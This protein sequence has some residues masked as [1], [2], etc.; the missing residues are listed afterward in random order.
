LPFPRAK[1]NL[2]DYGTRVPLAIRWGARV[3]PRRVV[4][5]FVSFPDFAPTFLEAAGLR[6]PCEMTGRSLLRV[7][8]S[9]RSGQ[10]DPARDCAVFGI[11]RGVRTKDY[12][13][14]R[15]LT[16]DASPAGDH[17]GP[18][19]PPDDPTGGYGDSDGGPSKT[20]LW[21]NREKYAELFRLAFGKRPAEELYD[22]NADP[23]Q[24]RNLAA[25]PQH[26]RARRELAARLDRHLR[27]TGDPRATGQGSQLDAVMR[28][29]PALGMNQA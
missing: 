4:E 7:L 2:Y 5:D 26:A 14:I 20:C 16:P 17:P 27:R 1:A 28:R 21:Q 25:D 10:V 6:A 18:V 3:P 8:L 24:L 19:W 29:Y 11:A 15:N 9:G 23:F 22:P 13:Y 12:L